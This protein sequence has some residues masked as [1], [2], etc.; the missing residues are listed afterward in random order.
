LGDDPL[1]RNECDAWFELVLNGVNR[2]GPPPLTFSIEQLQKVQ[3]PVLLIL[4]NKDQLVGNP[5]EVIPLA[6][7]VPD[8]VIKV[9]NS[10]HLIGMEKADEANRLMLPFLINK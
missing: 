9:L 6:E 7:N 8:I 10:A 5:Q 3:S 1:V 2:K 4:G